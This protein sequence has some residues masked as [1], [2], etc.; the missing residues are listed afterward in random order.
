MVGVGTRRRKERT[1]G[2]SDPGGS[3]VAIPAFDELDPSAAAGEDAKA[4]GE[5]DGCRLKAVVF[6][7]SCR[8]IDGQTVE[9]QR[10]DPRVER[11]GLGRD[12]AHLDQADIGV[13]V[14]VNDVGAAVLRP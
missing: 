4:S 2:G 6:G 7:G 8:E 11:E 10:G 12:L 14:A 3:V 9:L 1:S 5:G 13:G